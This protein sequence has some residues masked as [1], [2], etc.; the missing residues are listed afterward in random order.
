MST[1]HRRA[2]QRRAYHRNREKR[3]AQHRAWREANPETWLRTQS[4]E[5]VRQR[6]RQ[7]RIGNPDKARLADARKRHARRGAP[8]TPEAEAFA[9]VLYRDPCA[10]CDQSSE[11]LDHITPIAAGG[12]GSLDNLAGACASC[13]NRKHTRSLLLFLLDEPDRRIVHG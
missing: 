11:V 8:F 13:N 7:W 4:P 1:D 6:A 12:D 2:I 10:Y 3:L 9:P 5:Q